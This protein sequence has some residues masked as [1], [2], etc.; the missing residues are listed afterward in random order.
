MNFETRNQSAPKT[1]KTTRMTATA[2]AGNTTAASES[3]SNSSFGIRPEQIQPKAPRKHS[4]TP[5]S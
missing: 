5:V 4:K 3:G 1:H 2:S